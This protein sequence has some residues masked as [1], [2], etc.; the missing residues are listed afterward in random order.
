MWPIRLVNLFPCERLTGI[1]CAFR[2]TQQE[3]YVLRSSLIALAAI[4]SFG[5]MSL[6]SNPAHAITVYLCT[7]YAD[8]ANCNATYGGNCQMAT[9]AKKH[10]KG[11][12]YKKFQQKTRASTPGPSIAR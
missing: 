7:D 2:V 8:C 6:T 4:V 1:G 9:Q 5:T 11:T 3:I 10:P 12:I